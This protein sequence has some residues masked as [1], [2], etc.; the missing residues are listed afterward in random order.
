MTPDDM[1]AIEF[2]VPEDLDLILAAVHD[3]GEPGWPPPGGWG[4]YGFTLLPDG[5]HI[6]QGQWTACRIALPDGHPLGPMA[7]AGVPFCRACFD[8]CTTPTEAPQGLPWLDSAARRLYP[9]AQVFLAHCLAGTAS[10]VPTR[11]TAEPEVDG[12]G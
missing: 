10:G 4:D 2:D 6:V 12:L 8:V 7:P 11:P 1:P 3:W 5:F 9:S